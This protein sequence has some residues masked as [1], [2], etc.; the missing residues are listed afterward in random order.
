MGKLKKV[1]ET[2]FI[3]V[4]LLFIFSIKIEA[5]SV[6]TN[7]ESLNSSGIK[8][9][10]KSDDKVQKVII[11][12][13]IDNRWVQF[14]SSSEAWDNEKTFFI[15][16][17]RLSILSESDIKVK[18]IDENGEETS[19]E[20]HVE[21]LPETDEPESNITVQPNNI[22]IVAATLSPTGTPLVI[23][24]TATPSVVTPGTTP[25][26]TI[27]PTPT[28]KPVQTEIVR[29]DLSVSL[30]PTALTLA[31]GEKYQLTA[32]LNQSNIATTLTWSTSNKKA[33]IVDGNGAITAVGKGA[34]TIAVTLNNG[35]NAKCYVEVRDKSGYNTTLNGHQ[36]TMSDGDDRIYFLDV[37]DYVRHKDVKKFRY[38]GSDAIVIESNGKYGMIDAG[39]TYQGAR[40]VQ[41]LKD[42]GATELEFILITHA[43]YDHYGGFYEI[44]NPNNGIKVK[45]LY[46]K[47]LA[48]SQSGQ[49]GVCAKLIQAANTYN[50]PVFDV[51]LSQNKTLP[52]LGDFTFTLYNTVDRLAQK[53][54]EWGENVNSITTLAKIHGKKIYFAADIVNDKK[55]NCNA[56]TKSAKSV[57]KVAVYKV[58]HHSY[59]RNNKESALKRINPKYGIVTNHKNRSSTSKARSRILNYTRIT[60]KTLRYTATGTVILTIGSDGSFNF[61][62]LPAD[63][64]HYNYYQS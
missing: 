43:H 10:I 1:L 13:K 64:G 48:N 47:D 29:T 24:L 56:E 6:S 58:A 21:K 49:K 9:N 31:L 32:I 41:Y 42:I 54:S 60:S 26:I 44:V 59:D 53:N 25:R 39:V 61:K 22:P 51:L 52:N 33:V 40:V 50:V 46:I 20:K 55:I 36:V 16:S 4:I 57:G 18:V 45:S 11:Y 34:A 62:K 8:L 30:Q 17:K 27:N 19:S 35:R 3:I 7:V 23:T 37:S 28:L 14:F 5:N 63:E 15:P 12:K 38:E 2:I